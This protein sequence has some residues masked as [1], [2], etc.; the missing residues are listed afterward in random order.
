MTIERGYVITVKGHVE[1]FGF[2]EVSYEG[3][4]VKVFM[5]DIE[6]SADRVEG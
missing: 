5:Q 1:Q 4:T 3:Q 2:V 6:K